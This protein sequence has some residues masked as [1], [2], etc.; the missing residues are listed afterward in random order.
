VSEIIAKLMNK[1]NINEQE[2]KDSK[3]FLDN[4]IRRRLVEM[5]NEIEKLC[6]L[7]WVK[8]KTYMGNPREYEQVCRDSIIEL[9]IDLLTIESIIYWIIQKSSK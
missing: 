6:L 3:K 7:L 5:S 4:I 9:A 2:F 8:A 1:Y